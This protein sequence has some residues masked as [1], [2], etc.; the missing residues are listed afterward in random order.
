M[1]CVWGGKIAISE[2]IC[3]TGKR[4][5]RLAVVQYMRWGLT[6]HRLVTREGI[7]RRWWATGRWMPK[8]VQKD[9]QQKRC[10]VGGGKGKG[11]EGERKG[12]RGGERN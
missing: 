10:K 9:E 1:Y 7:K 3:W 8:A 11:G 2:T 12:K 5:I 6:R 4:G